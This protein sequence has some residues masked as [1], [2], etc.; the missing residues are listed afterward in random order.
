MQTDSILA[1]L[2]IV[3]TVVLFYVGLRRQIRNEK[4]TALRLAV[5][6]QKRAVDEAVR[7]ATDPLVAQLT[8]R[9]TERDYHRA[10]ADDLQDQLNRRANP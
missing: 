6:D 2:A 3:V 7:K 5:E 8:E 4:A 10:R 9:T 1:A